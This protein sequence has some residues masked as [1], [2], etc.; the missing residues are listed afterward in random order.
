MD[1][2]L[3]SFGMSIQKLSNGQLR[4]LS[5][6]KN[7]MAG[8]EMHSDFPLQYETTG[9]SSLPIWLQK[10]PN[11]PNL[12]FLTL[13][14]GKGLRVWPPTPDLLLGLLVPLLVGIPRRPALFSK[15]KP[16]DSDFNHFSTSSPN[17][18]ELSDLSEISP[19]NKELIEI[20]TSSEKIDGDLHLDW[21]IYSRCLEIRLP[22][23]TKLPLKN[24][25]HPHICAFMSANNNKDTKKILQH[26]LK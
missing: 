6:V 13:L 20:T 23:E 25:A 24:G 7:D 3:Q 15:P 17:W 26:T 9:E 8:W 12:S 16:L 21:L 19:N 22:P 18:N 14:Q 2:I 1:F 11:K 5:P 10:P 4:A